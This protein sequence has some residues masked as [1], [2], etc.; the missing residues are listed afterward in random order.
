MQLAIFKQ[1][2]KRRW[3]VLC[4]KLI[5]TMAV[6]ALI[7][8]KTNW[9]NILRILENVDYVLAV[10]V[11][12]LMIL[13]VTISAYKWQ[14]LLGIHDI[15]YPFKMLHRVY[16]IAV[17]A[18]NFFPSSIGGDGYRIART[19]GNAR[20]RLG[21]VLAVFIERASG[22]VLLLVAA[23]FALAAIYLREQDPIAGCIFLVVVVCIV[24]ALV[25]CF[26]VVR[27]GWI[28]R[29]IDGEGC[30]SSRKAL[31]SCLED[32]RQR[33]MRSAWGIGGISILFHVHT[34][35]F[36]W[37]LIYSLGVRID[38]LDLLVVIGTTTL[39]GF[40]P[41]TINGIGLMDGAFIVMAV[42]FG[43]D[44]EIA[45]STMLLVRGANVLIGLIGACFYLTS[46]SLDPVDSSLKLDN[47]SPEGP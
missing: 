20:S 6:C 44:R 34:V 37:L 47:P 19:L 9:G 17:F 28:H 24:V 14:V 42:H 30:P 1:S 40:L 39:V 23:A 5:I 25:G 15:Q 31:W 22:M 26:V 45:L 32:F 46:G 27:S 12:L 16:F 38:P 33:P 3:I 41:V 36:Y 4:A 18:N 21:A 35:F 2:K 10:A 29:L 7:L 11:F 8:W 43:L 13:S